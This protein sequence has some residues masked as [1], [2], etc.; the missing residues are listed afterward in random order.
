[1]AK[2]KAGNRCTTVYH[3]VTSSKHKLTSWD[4]T[5]PQVSHSVR[6]LHDQRHKSQ[7]STGLRHKE[8]A[9]SAGG[10]R[11]QVFYCLPATLC[12]IDKMFLDLGPTF[13]NSCARNTLMKFKDLGSFIKFYGQ[14]T[15]GLL[16]DERI[17]WV[18]DMEANLMR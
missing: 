8:Q 7:A 6:K 9:A 1:M 13:S 14:R 3:Q 18:L 5:R 15:E 10:P 4:G 12:H 2:A 17:L 16:Q 11:P